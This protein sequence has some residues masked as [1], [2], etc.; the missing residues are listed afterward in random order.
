M[1]GRA[2]WHTYI[3]HVPAATI[4]GI[5]VTPTQRRPQH[6]HIICSFHVMSLL[7]L[8][9]TT[10]SK[11]FSWMK[12]LQ[13]ALYIHMT[14]AFFL[15]HCKLLAQ[16]KVSLFCISYRHDIPLPYIL[17]YPFIVSCIPSALLQVQSLAFSRAVLFLC[18]VSCTML[19]RLQ[20]LRFAFFT[21][22]EIHHHYH[23]R[24]MIL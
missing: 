13:K 19:L 12:Y 20:L 18:F 16:A 22:D 21:H 2:L 4:S 11:Q 6:H 3:C 9:H 5:V 1:T 24:I 10:Q 8:P 7:L 17:W 15:L 14:C 23:E